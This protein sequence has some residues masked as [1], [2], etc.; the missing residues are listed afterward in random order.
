METSDELWPTLGPQVCDFIESFLVH[1]PGDILGQK[2]QLDEDKRGLIDSMYEVFPQDHEEA[3]RRRFKRVGLSLSKGWAKTELAAMIAACELH[4]DG[5]VRTVGW[6]GHGNP[7]GGGVT[8]PYIPMVSTTEEV[9][10]E[11]A[12]GA[13]LA[14]L[15]NSSI[16]Q[17]FDLGLERITRRDGTGK[18]EPVASSPNARDGARTTFQHFDETHRWVLRR[19]KKAHEAMLRNIPKRKKA[20]AWS[21]ETTTA[22]SPG[23]KSIAEETMDYARLVAQNKLGDSTLFYYHRSASDK[24]DLATEAG[25]RAAAIEAKGKD[26]SKWA[27]IRAIVA[28]FADPTANREYLKRIWFNMIVR[29]AGRAFDTERWKKLARS[30][31][32]IPAKEWITL[33]F[34]GSRF[35]DS[36]ALVAEHIPSRHQWLVGLWEKPAGAEGDGWSVPSEQVDAAVTACFERW[37]VWRMYADPWGW[38][39]E[40]A[41]WA[42]RWGSGKDGKVFEWP[43][44]R[45]A[46][47]ASAVKNFADAIIN[48]EITHDGHPELERHIGN[49]CRRTLSLKDASN[50][51]MWVIQKERPDSPMK[52]DGAMAAVLA[53]EAR[54]D[55][56]AAGVSGVSGP[57]LPIGAGEHERGVDDGGGPAFRGVRGTSF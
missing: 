51:P 37:K 16:A 41:T 12:Y 31:I 42:A 35:E 56:I 17:D 25:L 1:G 23:E 36:T 40:L 3:G 13:L 19:L 48:E 47:M 34:D 20:D 49:A 5:P 29:D 52:M 53:D 55:A 54:Q 8:D 11:L 50:V 9:T 39:S 2:V 27:D 18:A 32:V 33:G 38:G 43:T 57:L 45:W 44:N 6:D 14:I 7:I 21:L 24:H 4:P 26:A 46:Q 28:D 10:E 15:E 22:F 30:S